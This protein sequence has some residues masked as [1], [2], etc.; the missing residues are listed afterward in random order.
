[1]PSGYVPR[2]HQVRVAASVGLLGIQQAVPGS[3]VLSLLVT[4]LAAVLGAWAVATLR[5]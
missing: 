2:I 4:G 1:M 5:A 3:L